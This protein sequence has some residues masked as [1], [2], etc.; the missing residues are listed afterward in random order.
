MTHFGKMNV[1]KISII[2]A[3]FNQSRYI[4]RCIRSLLHQSAKSEDYE[5]IV[6][7]DGST[8]ETSVILEAFGTQ[9]RSHREIE[10]KGLPSAANIGIR[11]SRAPFFLR[12]DSDDF[13]NSE[14]VSVFVTYLT[15]NENVHGVA[16]DYLIVDDDE[17]VVSR[18]NSEKKPIACGVAFNKALAVSV[19]MYDESFL[20]HED[21]E[22]RSRFVRQF[23]I[24]RIPIPLYRYRRHS[25]NITNDAKLM[26]H[27]EERL[28]SRL[29]DG[30]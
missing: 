12:V 13:V 9:I 1:P 7:D 18:E 15:L 27:F 11:L 21:R 20:R 29:S 10:N 5:V 23:Q 3:T 2:V 4:S 22:F 30:E 14:F 28:D 16:C 19:G 6:V 24:E 17:I 26:L 25:S 8:D